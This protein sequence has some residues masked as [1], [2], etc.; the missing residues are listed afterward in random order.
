MPK[1][2]AWTICRK[3]GEIVCQLFGTGFDIKFFSKFVKLI[4]FGL[5]K[6]DDDDHYLR[7]T[8][9]VLQP[10]WN[11]FLLRIRSDEEKQLEVKRAQE[12][13]Q[14]LMEKSVFFEE[15]KREAK[16]HKEELIGFFAKLLQEFDG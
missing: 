14:T 8:K 9:V 2:Q 7:D 15:D 1:T 10:T 13:F 11:K 6:D 4:N 16:L 12:I 5:L 3:N